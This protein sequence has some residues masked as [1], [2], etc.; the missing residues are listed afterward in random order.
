[1][2]DCHRC[3]RICLWTAVSFAHPFQKS[4]LIAAVV[5]YVWIRDGREN[6]EEIVPY[7]LFLFCIVGP[8]TV[9]NASFG[10]LDTNPDQVVGI[11]VG[12]PF[13]IQKDES[14][15]EVWSRNVDRVD[16]VLADCQRLQGIMMFL[17]LA[18]RL[19]AAS[20]RTKCV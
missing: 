20:A 9:L 14:A 6:G 16:L 19:P 17:L 4:G 2:I 1:M 8:E 3:W 7:Q 12:Q 15:F 5:D 13:D 18:P 10:C 11:A